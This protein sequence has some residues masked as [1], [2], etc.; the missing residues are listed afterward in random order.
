[1]KQGDNVIA[2]S[3]NKIFE[4]SNGIWSSRA[5]EGDWFT[6]A[7]GPNNQ[8]WLGGKGILFTK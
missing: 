8:L 4:Y 6:A 3:P 1:L 2:V 7:I 5:I